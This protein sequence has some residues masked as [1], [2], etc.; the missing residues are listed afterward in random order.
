MKRPIR[1][2][3]IGVNHYH[4]LDM[5]KALLEGGAE[6]VSFCEPDPVNAAKFTAQFPH[7][8]AHE[9]AAIL[10]DPTIQMIASAA[11]PC[12]R[13]SLGIEV[14][15]HGKDYFVDKAGVTSLEQLAEVRRVQAETQRIY[16]IY[17]GERF[18]SKA[19]VKAAEMARAGAIGKVIQ[20]IGLGPHRLN[21]HLRPTWF[22][23]LPQTG[24]IL[25]DLAS[26][27]MDQ[28]LYFTNSIQADVVAAHVANYHNPQTPGLQD[29]GEATLVGNGGRGYCRVDWF[30][31]N[32]LAVY[33]DT[34][35]MVLGTDG[36]IDL[37]KNIDIDGKPGANHFLLVD[38]NGTQRISVDDF[39]LPFIG[40]FL[41]D[42]ENRT[43]TA[44]SQTHCF[45][46]SELAL[47][48]QA[49]G[50]KK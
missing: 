19:T 24:G 9:K 25:C 31:P 22:F 33:G 13:A 27:Q 50:Q 28:F 48:A 23:D 5:T 8:V 41:N 14:M 2:A 32:G 6:L 34:R 37:R 21:A 49:L 15:R 44:M 35:C 17:Y 7:A 3:V 45:L 11:V 36:Y 1:F 26:H 16:S 47:K 20:T 30:T 46:A 10:E 42:I 12:D 18:E 40:Q 4:I 39:Q 38:H 43:E 29:F